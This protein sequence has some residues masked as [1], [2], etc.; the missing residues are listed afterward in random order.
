[1]GEPLISVIIPIYN[2]Q[3]VLE[4]L[5]QRLTTALESLKETFEVILVDD[6]SRDKSLEML[7]DIVTKDKR[8]KFLSFSR[9]FGHQTA[10]TAG[11]NVVQGKA[12][13]IMDADLQDPPEELPRFLEK[14]KEGN[15]VVYAIRRRRK[16]GVIKRASYAA[17]YR[18]LAA[19][20]DIHI[21]LDSGDFCLMDRR[22]VDLLNRLPERNRFVR[23]IR[24]W[25]GFKQVGL[26]YERHSRFAGDTKYS[27]KKLFK[28]AFDGMI[29]FSSLPLKLASFL[30]FAVSG[31]AVLGIMFTFI[32]R[33]FISQFAA[34]GLKPVPGF[35][36]TMI[37]MLFLGGVQLICL[38]IIGEYL[39]R[40]YDE[41]KQR[42]LYVL[43]EV[44][45]FG[46]ATG[47][48]LLPPK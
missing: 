16:E 44:S 40:I 33:V 35:A 37:T 43:R 32:Q 6:G 14:W 36:T 8:Y 34:W 5:Y 23:G 4:T 24:S 41:V 17:F 1:M 3:A 26:E 30:G 21:P 13:V 38:G 19:I 29:S 25:L 2:E 47:D 45:G 42:P 15:D 22:I 48:L 18:L 46:E 27:L 31:V 7:R 12:I 28:L 10:I 20:S 11:L 39:G 9:N